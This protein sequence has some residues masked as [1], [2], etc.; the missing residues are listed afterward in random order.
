MSGRGVITNLCEVLVTSPRADIQNGVFFRRTVWKVAQAKVQRHTKRRILLQEIVGKGKSLIL[1]GLFFFPTH[2][3]YFISGWC[4]SPPRLL[5]FS[6]VKTLSKPT[7]TKWNPREGCSLFIGQL[8]FFPQIEKWRRFTLL[9]VSQQS[10]YQNIEEQ[11]GTSLK[12]LKGNISWTVRCWTSRRAE[13]P[14]MLG[15]YSHISKH[16]VAMAVANLF[17]QVLF[18]RRLIDWLIDYFYWQNFSWNLS[19]IRDTCFL[20]LHQIPTK[21]IATKMQHIQQKSLLTKTSD[22]V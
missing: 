7:T 9:K 4:V 6:S 11:I 22:T 2:R 16:G 15:H 12:T 3:N 20:N 10:L 13:L 18:F 1:G 19:C 21:Q 8:F 17:P 14:W 5:W